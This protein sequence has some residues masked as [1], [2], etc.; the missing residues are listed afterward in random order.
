MANREIKCRDLGKSPA[1]HQTPRSSTI[2][3]D[4]TIIEKIAFI[5][6]TGEEEG[7]ILESAVAPVAYRLVEKELK[8]LQEDVIISSVE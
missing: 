2:G 5:E 6:K 1:C 8:R 7:A 3:A 4:L